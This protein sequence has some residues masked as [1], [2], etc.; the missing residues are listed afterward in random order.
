M[1]GYKSI[2]ECVKGK[3][4]VITG[5]TSG[6]GRACV[7]TFCQAGVN[8]VTMGRSESK[9][10]EIEAAINA[11]GKGQCRYF[12]CDVK[13]TARL[14]EVIEMAPKIFGGIDM[15][16]NVAG[17]FPTQH[18]IDEI[19]DEMFA[20]V[21]NTNFRAYFMAAKYALPYLR[22][23][24]GSIVNIGSV[25]AVTGGQGCEAYISTKGAIETFT[26][27][28]AFDEAPNGVRVNEVKPGH[29]ETEISDQLV[30]EK[31][32]AKAFKEFF[33]HV[34]ILGR[35]GR[36]EEVARA[37]LFMASEWGSFITGTDLMVSGGYE[38]GEAEKVLSKFLAWPEPIK[39]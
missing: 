23:A 4:A 36:P 15:L 14:K 31:E 34:Q 18:P 17:Y 37:C 3:T 11:L 25:T 20:D 38:L 28:L 5:G 33:D 7:E 1:V 32:D 29:I 35:G 6:I 10:K 19:T 8:V 30:G 24:K 16:V 2:E 9:G 26:R 22:T 12:A 27:A 21:F 39:K 13:D